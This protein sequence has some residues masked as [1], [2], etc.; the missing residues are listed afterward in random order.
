MTG[1]AQPDQESP[2]PLVEIDYLD[3]AAMR[4]DVRSQGVER[5]FNAIDGI[6]VRAAEEFLQTTSE[7]NGSQ[8][9]GVGS[10]EI[11]QFRR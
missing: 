6:H 8:E 10:Q 9:S 11:A 5:F 7:Y 2:V 1:P 4:R 3:L